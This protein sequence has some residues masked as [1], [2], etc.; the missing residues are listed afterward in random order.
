MGLWAL[1]T[2]FFIGGTVHGWASIVV[3]MYF[4]GG[5]QLLTL[6]IIGIYISKVY[7]EVKNQDQNLL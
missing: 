2:K 1:I 5:I 6:G 4:L 3:P 7:L